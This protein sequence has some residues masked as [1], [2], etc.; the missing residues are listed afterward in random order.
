[1]S[2]R[3]QSYEA[4]GITVTFD[5]TRCIHSG[6]CVRGLPAVFDVHRKRWVHAEAASPDAIVAQIERC[7]SGALQYRR[8]GENA[9]SEGDMP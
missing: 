5:P 2:T 4:P 6:V 9:M 7:P 8:T 3:L 1:M